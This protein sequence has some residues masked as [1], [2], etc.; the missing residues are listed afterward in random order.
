MFLMSGANFFLVDKKQSSL[1]YS[2][3]IPASSSEEDLNSF[4]IAEIK[5]KQLTIKS[6]RQWDEESSLPR[7]QPILDHLL[8]RMEQLSAEDKEDLLHI[9]TSIIDYWIEYQCSFMNDIQESI[10][11]E[12]PSLSLGQNDENSTVSEQEKTPQRLQYKYLREIHSAAASMTNV[13]E[14]MDD[15]TSHHFVAILKAWANTCQIA[16]N[17]GKT[18]TAYVVGVPQ[19]AQLI[20]N[21]M[22]PDATVEAYNEVIKAWAYSSEYLRGTMAEQVFQKIQFPTGESFQ[23]IMRAHAWSMESRSAFH[24]TGQFMRMMR[25]LEAGRVDMEPPSIDEYH[26]LCRAWTEAGDKNSSSKVY[27]AL[28]IMETAYQKGQTDLRADLQCYRDALITMSRRHNVDN[29]G[30]LADEIL[31]E[32]KDQMMY[33]DTECYRSAIVAWKHVAM[34]RDSPFPE[35]AIRR[36]QDL[37]QEMT[38]A[39]HRTNQILIQPTTEDYNNVLQAMALSKNQNSARYAQDLFKTLKEE[40][41]VI[42]GPDAQSYRHMLGVWRNSRS[43]IKFTHAQQLLQE[44]KENYVSDKSLRDNKSPNESIVD[45]F[46]TFVQVCG[47]PNLN[48]KKDIQEQ[49]KIMTMALR[50]L[51]DTRKLGLTPNSETYTALVEA[52]DNLLPTNRQERQGVLENIFHRAC[53]EGFVNESLLERF[54]SV[55]STYLYVKLVVSKSLPMEDMKIVPESWTRNVKGYREGKKVMPLSIHGNFAFTK[56][57][58]E[59]R[60]RKLRRRTNQKLLQGGRL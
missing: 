49:T 27:S 3:S 4:S 15:P 16:Y 39:Y 34:S 13:L 56:S 50:I 41:S 21:T 24:A 60:M 40:T 45:V 25:L 22:G 14:S 2:S 53:R 26:I 59:Y 43:P 51:E 47:A 29:V 58:A 18:K 48:N 7:A 57:A 55:A 38:E 6:L 12:G 11:K 52:C 28:R 1:F 31:K 19:R 9:Q 10:I 42:G 37:L 5:H 33:P 30:E 32:M 54:K 46:T 36:T 17:I 35:Q 23:M 44:V 8:E 20:L